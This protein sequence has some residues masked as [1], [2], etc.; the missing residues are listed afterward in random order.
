MTNYIYDDDAAP[1]LPKGTVIPRVRW[2]DNT[3]ANK[4]TP[5]RIVGRLRRPHGRRDGHAWITSCSFNDDEYQALQRSAKRSWR[6]RRTTT[7]SSMKRLAGLCAAGLIAGGVLLSGKQTRIPERA[8]V[9]PRSPA[10]SKAVLQRRRQPRVP[11]RI[12]QSQHAAEIAYPSAQQPD[13]AGR[14]RHGAARRISFRAAVGMFSFPVPK[15]SS[16][17][18]E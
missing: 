11:G 18:N 9:R 3:R 12:F 16:P 15:I 10:R 7:R 1:L 13:R 2:Y 6:R 8:A 4:N 14:A 17:R 5:I